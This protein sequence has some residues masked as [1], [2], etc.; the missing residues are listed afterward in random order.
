MYGQSGRGQ[1]R[2]QPNSV[3]IDGQGKAERSISPRGYG[4]LGTM[5]LV[6]PGSAVVD[7]DGLAVDW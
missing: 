7:E 4:K 5:E 6:E 3:G 2:V 1:V